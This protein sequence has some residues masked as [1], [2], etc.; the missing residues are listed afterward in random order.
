MNS[1]NLLECFVFSKDVNSADLPSIMKFVVILLVVA[2][3]RSSIPCPAAFA[4]FS[5]P[6]TFLS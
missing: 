4:C 6:A 3:L 1:V 5:I 2:C